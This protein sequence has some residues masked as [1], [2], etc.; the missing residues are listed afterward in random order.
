[1]FIFE[2]DENVET[3]ESGTEERKET[4]ESEPEAP[5]EGGSQA[6][7]QD[8]LDVAEIDKEE[9]V[10][11]KPEEEA[12]PAAPAEST[13]TEEAPAE[14]EEE[15]LGVK[16][17]KLLDGEFP[18]LE[19]L[20]FDG[21]YPNLEEKHLQKMDSYSKRI[22]H[23]LRVEWK[24]A[25]SGLEDYKTGL[26]KGHDE[27]TRSL[28]ER[29]RQLAMESQ[30]LHA[31]IT[32]PQ[33][34][35]ALTPP[36]I[37][38]DVDPLSD[39]GRKAEIRREVV[40]TVGAT[41]KPME[42]SFG[43]IAQQTTLLNF[44]H[45][46]PEANDLEF[47]GEMAAYIREMNAGGAKIGLDTAYEVVKGRRLVKEADTKKAGALA[48]RQRSGQRVGKRT[49]QSQPG[50]EGVPKEVK[51]KGAYAVVQWLQKHPKARARIERERGRGL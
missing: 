22:M 19:E 27:R 21:F 16:T 24:K 13:E 43:K 39:E 50:N 18:D 49:T 47:K 37:G 7:I 30:R 28:A 26:D 41:L 9:A 12:A 8:L 35:A 4:P 44:Y 48:A 25:I 23:N 38:D 20:E 42:D 46:H 14:P 33:V 32:D 2:D 31:W 34:K 6:D 1:M 17:W 45:T 15:S 5:S 36:E 3:S 40:E 10:E 29:E 11:T 51:K